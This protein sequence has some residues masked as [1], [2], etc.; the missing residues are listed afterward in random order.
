MRTIL[1]VLVL[2]SVFAGIQIYRLVEIL[3]GCR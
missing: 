2:L 3:R 1:T